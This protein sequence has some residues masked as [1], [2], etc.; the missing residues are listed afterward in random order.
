M[1]Q[2]VVILKALVEVAMCAFL[3]QGI[4]YILA[5]SKREQ[6]FVYGI[7]KTLTNPVTW[8]ARFISP[9][10]V[11]DQHIWLV[12]IFLLVAAWVALTLAKVSLVLAPA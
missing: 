12:A 8:I 1:L 7:M 5:G 9:R 3:G 11:L 2:F 4:L 10:F 6:N